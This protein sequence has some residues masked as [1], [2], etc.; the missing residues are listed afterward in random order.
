M[1]A[2]SDDLSAFIGALDFD[3]YGYD[4]IV[5]E[6]E[7]G[8]GIVFSKGMASFTDTY[9]VVDVSAGN[10]E[11]VE[12]LGSIWNDTGDG[13]YYMTAEEMEAADAAG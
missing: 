4:N 8:T 10:F 12:S 1:K 2:S 7:D 5:L 3:S 9:G 6:F 11:I 13:W